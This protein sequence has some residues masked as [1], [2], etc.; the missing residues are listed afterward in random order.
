MK[1]E[2]DTTKAEELLKTGEIGAY[3]IH[4]STDKKDIVMTIREKPRTAE[5]YG[6]VHHKYKKYGEDKY[7]Q[8]GK[9]FYTL[10]GIWEAAE[11]RSRKLK[12]NH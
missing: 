11:I 9:D 3:I 7:S 12:E 1:M 2:M 4:K 8:N 6:V 5:E 10:K